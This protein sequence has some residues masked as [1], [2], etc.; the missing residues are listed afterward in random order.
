MTKPNANTDIPARNN[1]SIVFN[2][3][4][5]ILFHHFL[6]SWGGGGGG[7]GVVGA[8]LVGDTV[9]GLFV[10]GRSVGFFVVVG[11]SVVGVVVVVGLGDVVVFLSVGIRVG[12][13]EGDDEVV[14]TFD[15][16]VWVGTGED[17]V[18]FPFSLELIFRSDR[19]LISVIFSFLLSF[20]REIAWVKVEERN[21]RSIA[22]RRERI[23]WL[24]SGVL[25]WPVIN[26][27]R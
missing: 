11:L 9:V 26:L 7:F 15:E 20:S 27:C 1:Q 14:V 12:A 24:F 6:W 18:W 19:L 16:G 22:W 23:F 2:I 17:V 4:F 13:T 25:L 10:V 21:E 8:V 5:H 3:I